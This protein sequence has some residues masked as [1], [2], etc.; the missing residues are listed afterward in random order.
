M[1]I[2]WITKRGN[3]QIYANFSNTSS[4]FSDVE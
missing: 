3:A 4:Q 1:P 2:G